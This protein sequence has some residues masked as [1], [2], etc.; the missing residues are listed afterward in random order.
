MD[1]ISQN[2][3]NVLAKIKDAAE[4]YNRDPATITLLNVSKTKPEQMVIQAYQ[5][6]QRHFGESY[7]VEASEKIENLKNQGYNDIVWHFI[8]PIQKNKTKLIAEHFD[9]VESVDRAIVAKRLN[10][11]RPDHLG[12]LDV[13]VQVNISDEEQ[14]SGCSI[15]QIDSIIDE[16]QNCS[17]LR[18]RGF[19]GIG[20]DTENMQL[21]D[22]EFQKLHDLFVKYK[23]KY[24]DFNILSLGMTNDLEIA[25]KNDSTQVRIGT[26]IFGAREY[27]NK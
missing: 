25:I 5:A 6:G 22:S 18:L 2:I 4:K 17:K 11:Q 24:E 15:E 10:D 13:L 14:K 23:E 20:L 21:I 12:V 16:I 1:K 26:A 27:K 19:M 8:G 7:A 9:I 3:Q